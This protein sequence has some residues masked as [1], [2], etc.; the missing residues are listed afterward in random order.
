M[1]DTEALRKKIIELA[2]QGKLTEQ[3]SSDG[4]A[5][6]LYVQIQEEK[7]KLIKEGK[8]KKE[9]QL[10]SISDD[11]IPFDIP[12]N[13]KW[14][15]LASIGD[16]I[17]GYTPSNDELYDEGNIPYFK[18]SDMNSE[19]NEL[20]LSHTILFLRGDSSTKQFR[21]NT[22]VYP[23][24]GGALLTNK[25]RILA[26][27]SV[28]DLNTGGFMPSR[29][30]CIG[31]AYLLFLSIDFQDYHKG[32]AVPTLDMMKM[33]NTLVPLPPFAEQ[34]R[35]VESAKTAFECVD[36]IKVFQQQYES[37][38]SVLKGKII[39]AGIRGKLTEQLPE[40][41]DAETLYSQ[42]QE[43]K[44]KLIK[45]GKIKKEKPLPEISADEIPFEIP[46]TWKWV[47]LYSITDKITDGTH[48]SPTNTAEGDYMYVTAKNIKP[49]GINL[50][51]ITYVSSDIHKEIYSRCNPEKNDVLL[52][53]DGAT[54][55]VVTV[56]NLDFPFSMLSSVALI[57]PSKDIEPWYVAY[58]MRSNWFTKHI[59][60]EMTGVGI[61]RVVLRQIESFVLPMPPY[62]EQ[63]RIANQIK[64]LHEII[65]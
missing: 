32:S 2:I 30:V 63:K 3:L 47:R 23:K 56:N 21:S 11:E 14:V 34:E 52:I 25:K 42:I 16:F 4:D 9:K 59:K 13:W 44:A 15:R 22:I 50:D 48:H 17:S 45:E 40:D 12:S 31:Y 8:V 65:L 10:T 33:R 57:K 18:V 61:T 41:G 54:T 46:K 20:Y 6:T 62:K 27:N 19:G 7:A 35:I 60:K 38:L 26:Q 58:A 55:G 43:Q 53:K 51:E 49:E 36:D 39:D 28:V 64:E 24:N 5:E 1:I 37:D 29:C